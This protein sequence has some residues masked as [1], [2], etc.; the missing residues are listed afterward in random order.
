V[1]CE[2]AGGG[3]FQTACATTCKSTSSSTMSIDC[4]TNADCPMIAPT[5]APSILLPG[6]H[7]CK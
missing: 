6:F 2:I 7:F 5:C 1:C 3:P 4:Y